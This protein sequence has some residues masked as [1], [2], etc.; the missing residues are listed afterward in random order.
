MSDAEILSRA[1]DAMGIDA[2]VLA[3]M[4]LPIITN[5]PELTIIEQLS[6]LHRELSQLRDFVGAGGRAA[7]F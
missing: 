5:N 3:G 7:G 1:A 2:M 6:Q 4:L